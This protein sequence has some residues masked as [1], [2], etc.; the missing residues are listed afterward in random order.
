MEMAILPW[1]L[2]GVLV[3][4]GAAWLVPR[5]RAA[6]IGVSVLLGVAGA[7]IGGFVAAGLGLGTVAEFEL[8][9]LALAL[10]G[11]LGMLLGHGWLRAI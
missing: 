4:A 6:G 2:L 7:L 8:Q 11:A 5:A 1:I 10:V 3:G 9:S